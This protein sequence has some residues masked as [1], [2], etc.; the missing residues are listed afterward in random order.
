MVEPFF[1]VKIGTPVQI[2][3]GALYRGRRILWHGFLGAWY[4]SIP[5]QPLGGWDMVGPPKLCKATRGSVVAL[6]IAGSMTTV[7]F[8]APPFGDKGA[9]WWS[10]LCE[11]CISFSTSPSPG[12]K[13]LGWHPLT[14]G[15]GLKLGIEK[16]CHTLPPP[17]VCIM[18]KVSWWIFL[19]GA[20]YFLNPP[21]KGSGWQPLTQ[22]RR[23]YQNKESKKLSTPP[24]PKFAF[25]NFGRATT[26]NCL[27]TLHDEPPSRGW[28]TS[29]GRSAEF[30][31]LRMQ[32]LQ[33][34]LRNNVGGPNFP[35]LKAPTS[36]T[37]LGYKLIMQTGLETGPRGWK[38]SSTSTRL[39]GLELSHHF[40]D[41]A[42]PGS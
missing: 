1:R 23:G 11:E 22:G 26:L 3:S 13:V 27:H 29:Q 17:K 39:A 40:C 5:P 30:R 31:K 20:Y 33:T 15:R 10:L 7:R 4:P 32:I 35:L 16:N 14:S 18:V 28:K 36:P 19:Q 12:R 9:L 42:Q 34:N 8:P 37:Q 25:D 38:R 21:R 41:L 6:M 2:F 24:S